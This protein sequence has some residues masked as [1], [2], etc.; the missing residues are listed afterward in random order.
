ML[1]FTF[2]PRQGAPLN[3]SDHCGDPPLLLAAG[4]GEWHGAGLLTPHPTP[5]EC[6]H[7]CA[8]LTTFMNFNPKSSPLPPFPPYPHTATP[9]PG[10][11]ACCRLLLEEGADI[12]QRNVMGESPII[13]AAH[14]GHMQ[15][16]KFLVEAGADINAIDMVRGLGGGLGGKGMAC[17][18][19]GCQCS[20]QHPQLGLNTMICSLYLK[21]LSLP[22]P[23]PVPLL[24]KPPAGDR[25][26]ALGTCL[27][28][29]DVRMPQ[30]D[31]TALHWA[32]MRGHVEIVKYLVQHGADKT[33][34]NKQVHPCCEVGDVM[35]QP[36]QGSCWGAVMRA[37]PRF[38]PL[39][40]PPPFPPR[41]PC[42]TSS[43]LT[44][45]SPAGPPP[46]ASLARCYQPIES[47]PN[48][49][50]VATKCAGNNHKLLFAWV[51]ISPHSY[52]VRL[53]L[54]SSGSWHDA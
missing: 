27:L 34:K 24:P 36:G 39:P 31:N 45:A 3:E 53:N 14:N 20:Y 13:R 9:P 19:A 43:P 48:P 23:P 7:A 28:I 5:I 32:A 18:L 4:N 8:A 21:Q 41:S 44:S 49:L 51:V 42:R 1:P 15:T 22:S 50:L 16:V 30:G 25:T 47:A 52:L 29:P 12:D 2:N 46:S 40:I 6:H 26:Q 17:S 11:L 38:P 35:C 37:L 10:H 33:L 54:E